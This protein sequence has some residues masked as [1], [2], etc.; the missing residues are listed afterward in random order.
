MMDYKDYYKILGIPRT[1]TPREIK[2]AFRALARQ[3]HP[4]VNADPQAEA[5]FKEVNEA[6]EVLSDPEKR[7]K[8]DQM[9]SSYS[10]WQGT[11]GQP[12]GFDWSPFMGGQPGGVRVEYGDASQVFS[13]F[14]NTFFGGA[15]ARGASTGGS[16]SSLDDL[17]RSGGPSVRA[18]ARDLETTVDITLDEAYHGTTRMVTIGSRRLQVKIPAGARTGTVVRLSGK[19]AASGGQSGDLYLNVVVQSD[20]RFE[21]EGDDLHQEIVLDLYVAV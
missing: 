13:E 3:Y 11:G 21:R 4:D 14:F 18:G 15:P 12:G 6:Y 19:G 8:Y 7:R 10:Q 9:G 16:F 17:L 1:A 5:R 2:Q 20:P